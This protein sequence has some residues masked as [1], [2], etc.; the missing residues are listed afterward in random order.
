MMSDQAEYRGQQ[1]EK[2][3]EVQVP[4]IEQQE[5]G[6][7]GEHP[8]AGNLAKPESGSRDRPEQEEFARK[9]KSLDEQKLEL[10]RY[11]T[12]MDFLKFMWGSVV[13]A[14]AIAAIPPL[15]Q[16][17]TAVL[18]NAQA[19]N[20]RRSKE[21]VFNAELR[22]KQQ[23]FRDEYVKTFVTNALDRDIENRIRLAQYFARVT[24]DAF[25]DGWVAYRDEL[26]KHKE[27]TRK[28]IDQTEKELQT[29]ML[30]EPK[31]I[32]AIERIERHLRWMNKEIGNDV[33]RARPIT[34]PLPNPTLETVP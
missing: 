20:E 11:K 3:A 9:E 15:F 19:D 28:G 33:E 10:E 34:A 7:F 12:K 32:L 13:A 4:G 26:M 23:T 5:K 8:E 30:A 27:D 21:L 1:R 17:A 18:Q 29:M 6:V 24:T 16:L 31:D 14:I 25:R 2:N 22:L